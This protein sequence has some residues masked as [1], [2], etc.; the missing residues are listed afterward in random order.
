M[1]NLVNEKRQLIDAR[2]K[3]KP[4]PL[5]KA[6]AE[7]KESLTNFFE[8]L[9]SHIK[10]VEEAVALVAEINLDLSRE[11]NLEQIK[12]IES[13]GALAFM[14]DVTDNSTDFDNV[15]SYIKET[16]LPTLLYEIVVDEYQIYEAKSKEV[17]SIT[18]FPGLLELGELQYFLE[19]CRELHIEPWLSIRTKEAL[20]IAL[21]TDAL[22]LALH[23]NFSARITHSPNE[24]SE[25]I[26]LIKYSRRDF[27]E[28]FIVAHE[29]GVQNLK[30]VDLLK[31]MGISTFL[32][33]AS[34]F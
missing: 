15:F 20:E 13:C 12:H 34:M 11:A 24:L 27:K 32:I 1:N 3:L 18:L 31:S 21:K 29:R 5:V 17:S 28:F 22:I 16:T 14:L 6:L 19:I 2:K 33:P 8:I 26:D 7:E 25:I 10:S 4:L 9:S 23:Q 30:D